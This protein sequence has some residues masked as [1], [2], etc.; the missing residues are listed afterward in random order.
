MPK[1]S[2]PASKK[3]NYALQGGGTHGA[4]T[5]GILDYLLED[6]RLEAEAITATSAGSMNAVILLQGLENGGADGA[7]ALLETFWTEISQAGSVL[8]PVQRTP[9]EYFSGV[10]PVAADWS[11]K[12]SMAFAA[13]SSFTRSVS[14]YQFNPFDINPLR[15]I[16]EKLVDFERLQ[17]CKKA[18]LFISATNVRTG[19]ARVFKTP[20]ITLDVVMA[21]AA[22]PFLFKAVEIEGES[23]WDG[24]YMGNPSLWPLFY[25]AQTRDTLIMHVNPITRDVIPTDAAGIENRINEITFNSSL[26]LEMRAILFVKKLI[27]S[28]MLKDEYKSHYKDVLLHAIRAETP[29]SN[30]SAASKFDTTL[31]FLYYM[32][33]LGRETARD[34][35]AE[36]YNDIGKR[37][38]VDIMRNY[39]SPKKPEA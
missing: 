24:G 4:F 6:G 1:P 32:R 5:W 23:Y 9:F 15:D 20:E 34:W 35:L 7:R 31:Q 29:M 16:I 13:F 8:S 22:L 14:P 18:K 30:L 21:S 25:H 26:L 12:N 2:Q 33:D 3:I 37:S 10:N 39:L 11:L 38:T 17:A 36:N 28:D 19:D 27:H